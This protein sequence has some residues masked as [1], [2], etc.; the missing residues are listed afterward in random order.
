[1]LQLVPTL[2]RLDGQGVKVASATLPADVKEA[3]EGNEGM[4]GEERRGV[5]QRP[6]RAAYSTTT[7]NVIKTSPLC[8][9]FRL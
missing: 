6:N 7:S 3:V 8:A 5:K 2:E 1:M 9:S 4:S